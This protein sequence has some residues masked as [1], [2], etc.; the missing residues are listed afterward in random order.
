[1]RYD[2]EFL[3]LSK[4][5]PPPT[6]VLIGVLKKKDAKNY[7]KNNKKGNNRFLFKGLQKMNLE[8]A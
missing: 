4:L 8:H 7:I 6:E 5:R 3:K 1:M 2:V